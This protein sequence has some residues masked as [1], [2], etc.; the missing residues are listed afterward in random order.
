M[1]EAGEYW[2]DAAFVLVLCI[3]LARALLFAFAL[4]ALD[5]GYAGSLCLRSPE[6]S[7]LANLSRRSKYSGFMY[8]A[9]IPVRRDGDLDRDLDRYLLCLDRLRERDLDLER[10]LLLAE[11]AL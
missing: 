6:R 8:F 7:P 9:G 2:L 10:D 5:H 1:A 3:E 11:F 4:F